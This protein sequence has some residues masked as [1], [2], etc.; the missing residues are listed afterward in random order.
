MT[1]SYALEGL[2]LFRKE[3]FES[4]FGESMLAAQTV[5]AIEALFPKLGARMC[6][7]LLIDF[8]KTSTARVNEFKTS[9]HGI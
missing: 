6:A 2:R 9:G 3:E 1:D 5:R 7:Y 8:F 4:L